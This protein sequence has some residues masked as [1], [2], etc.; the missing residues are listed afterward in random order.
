M[1]YMHWRD[2]LSR[3]KLLTMSMRICLCLFSS[4]QI[5]QKDGHSL[6]RPASPN[7][8][9]KKSSNSALFFLVF[10]LVSQLLTAYCLSTEIVL[11]TLLHILKVWS[12]IKVKDSW[13][14]MDEVE[15][16]LVHFIFFFKLKSN[17]LIVHWVSIDMY[18]RY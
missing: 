14:V 7:K 4:M 15:W 12:L 3:S 13:Y 11:V 18:S 1:S 8:Y 2:G 10:S 17:G 5:N 6:G 9:E 16:M